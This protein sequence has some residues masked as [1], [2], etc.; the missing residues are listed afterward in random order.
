M[1]I[2]KSAKKAIR[3][4][5]KKKVFN[6]RRK[7]KVEDSVKETFVNQAIANMEATE[8]IFNAMPVN[9]KSPEVSKLVALKD[10]EMPTNTMTY[11]A[12]AKVENQK[13]GYNIQ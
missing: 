1:P 6:L 10:G 12:K 2:T 13:R 4:S 5:E 9:V 7:K 3:G 8:A 11:M